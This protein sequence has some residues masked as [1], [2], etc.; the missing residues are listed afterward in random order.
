MSRRRIEILSDKA[1]IVERSRQIVCDII[2]D[3][4]A[5]QGRCT[6]ALAGGSTPKPLYEALAK[7]SIDW[8]KLHI[9]WGDERYVAPDHPDSNE[10]MARSAWLNHV[11]IPA[12]NI[13]PMPTGMDDPAIAADAYEKELKDFFQVEADHF[14]VL[15]L[16]LL[17]MGDDGHTASLFPNT[18]ALEVRDRWVTVGNKQ[19]SIRITLTIPLLNHAKTT[20]F[21]V[22]GANKNT[23]LQNVLAPS[24]SS[25]DSKMFPSRFIQPPGNL[26]WLLDQAADGECN[27]GQRS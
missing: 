16:V 5:T 10:R 4:I 6:M 13:H 26:W 1:A 7:E 24:S 18:P 27:F 19:D 23:A 20:I 14:P 15:D 22:S 12:N 17:G 21:L 11:S 9:F 2:Q 25:I 3:S 8:S